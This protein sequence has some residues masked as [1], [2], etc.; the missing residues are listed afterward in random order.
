M[1]DYLYPMIVEN[2]PELAD[3]DDEQ[4]LILAGELWKSATSQESGSPQDLS[5]EVVQMLEER[6]AHLDANPESG[7]PWEKLRDEKLRQ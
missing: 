6:L 5:S 7:I 4:K 3:L 2:F 1:K